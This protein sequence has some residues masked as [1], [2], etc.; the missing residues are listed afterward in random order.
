MPRL[1]PAEARRIALSAQKI[2][3]ARSFGRGQTATLNAIRHL[4]YIQLDTI[5]V[6]QRAHHHTL[7]NRAPGYRPEH[8]DRLQRTKQIFEYWSHAAAY[9][10]IEDYRFCLP[11]MREFAGGKK[12]WYKQNKKLN[13]EVLARIRGEGPLQAR[14]FEHQRT[15]QPGWWEWKPAKRALENLFMAGELCIT[16]REGFQKVYDL[17]ERFLPEGLNTAPPTAAEFSRW[18]IRRYLQAHGIALTREISYLRPSTKPG[19]EK[20]LADMQEQGEVIPLQLGDARYH[21]LPDFPA[22]LKNRQPRNK[23]KILSPFDNLLIQRKRAQALFDFDY[24]IECYTPA[25]KRIYGYFTLPLLWGSRLVGRM[26]AKAA[27]AEK[28]FVVKNL[29]LEPGLKD[30]DQFATAFTAALRAFV[31]F[32]G[33]VD[34]EVERV[35]CAGVKEMVLREWRAAS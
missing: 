10:S 34:L 3:P 31:E 2:W 27:R 29:A 5:S 26:D 13:A 21:A 14:D 33:C 11:R 9:L 16:H 35:S 28:R 12:H 24:Q 20:A 19:I 1:S 17:T 32:N 30:L 6:V 18:L 23:I 8:L 22:L 4:G 7:W 25:P 15:A